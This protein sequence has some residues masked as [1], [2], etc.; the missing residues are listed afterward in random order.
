MADESFAGR[1]AGVPEKFSRQFANRCLRRVRIAG[2][3]TQNRSAVSRLLG[4]RSS[5][6]Q[7]SGGGKRSGG[8]VRPANRLDVCGGEATASA[9]CRTELAQSG[10]PMA[11]RA[12]AEALAQSHG[13]GAA[14]DLAPRVARQ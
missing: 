5:R 7:R 3:G 8:V 13:T 14:T 11:E 1:S 10:A 4:A 6:V 2:A 9:A 12:G